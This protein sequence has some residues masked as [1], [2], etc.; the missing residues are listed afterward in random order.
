MQHGTITVCKEPSVYVYVFML[1][2][3]CNLGRVYEPYLSRVL[4][5]LKKTADS[6]AVKSEVVG[7]AYLEEAAMKLF[8]K[9]DNDDRSA[10]FNK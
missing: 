1:L 10:V 2:Y 3:D 9:A 7:Q 6:E 4:L 8:L 5:Q